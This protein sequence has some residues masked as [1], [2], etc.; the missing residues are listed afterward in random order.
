MSENNYQQA[1]SQLRGQLEEIHRFERGYK[2]V[3]TKR[4]TG[5]LASCVQVPI[6]VELVLHE[7]GSP[8]FSVRFPEDTP[9][10]GKIPTSFDPCHVHDFRLAERAFGRGELGERRNKA[11][12]KAL[13]MLAGCLSFERLDVLPQASAIH[14]PVT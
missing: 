11:F 12:N 6:E 3:M 1:V 14:S 7:E 5:L 4:I 9:Q 8:V 13:G 2:S 10:V